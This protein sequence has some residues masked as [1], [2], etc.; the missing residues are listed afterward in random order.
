MQLAGSRV[1]VTGGAVRIGREIC[2]TLA[3][4]GAELVIHYHRSAAEALELQGELE[5]GGG[6]ARTLCADLSAPE[7]AVELMAA[8][9]P[10]DVLVNNASVFHKDAL[11]EITHDAL[12]NEF[13]PNLFAPILL[14]REFAR[15]SN[16]GVVINLLDQRIAGLDASAIPYVLSKKALAEFTRLAALA[17][18]PAVRVNGVAPGA[19]LPPPGKGDEYLA[20]QAGPVPLERQCTAAEVAQAVLG[21]IENDAVTGQVVF[22]DGG[23]HLLGGSNGID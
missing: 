3:A 18:A 20:D 7:A 5:G 19:I 2:R 17:L 11:P 8:A 9:G 10:L 4:R 6:R 12:L 23:Q 21:L 22:V 13:A 16:R 15:R 1:L 14:T